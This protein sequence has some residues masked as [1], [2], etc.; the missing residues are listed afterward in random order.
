MGRSDNDMFMQ[1]YNSNTIEEKGQLIERLSKLNATL[2]N[3]DQELRSKLFDYNFLNDDKMPKIVTPDNSV[4]IFDNVMFNSTYLIDLVIEAKKMIIDYF[5]K[6]EKK[7]PHNIKAIEML[8]DLKFYYCN[9]PFTRAIVFNGKHD[10]EKIMHDFKSY[11]KEKLSPC[12]M[13]INQNTNDIRVMTEPGLSTLS[14]TNIVDFLDE[15]IGYH[16]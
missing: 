12:L 11:E 13:Y 9:N 15:L 8:N 1:M 10:H 7:E 16:D 14:V 5:E 2:V 6:S 3:N 4:I